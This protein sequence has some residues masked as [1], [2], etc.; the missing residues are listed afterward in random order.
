V[1]EGL[2]VSDGGLPLGLP[3]GSTVGSVEND[4]DARI[5]ARTLGNR[6]WVASEDNT[7]KN[8]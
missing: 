1:E 7:K 8:L 3:W 4:G 2:Q 6:Q 5:Q